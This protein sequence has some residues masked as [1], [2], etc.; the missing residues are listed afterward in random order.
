MEHQLASEF[1]L[2]C[3]SVFIFV[4]NKTK[5]SKCDVDVAY[6]VGFIVEKH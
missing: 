3:C 5:C 2:L 6:F 1:Q 4:Q